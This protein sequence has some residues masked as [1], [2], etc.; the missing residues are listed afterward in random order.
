MAITALLAPSTKFKVTTA[1][2]A[3]LVGGKVYTYIAASSTLTATYADA[4]RVTTNTNPVI[5]DSRGEANIFLDPAINYKFVVQDSAGGSV[6]TQDNISGAQIGV[7]AVTDANISNTQSVLLAITNKLLTIISGTGAVY[8]S[9]LARLRDRVSLKD[10]GAVGDG[11]TN[12]TTAVQNAI[13]YALGAGIST[14]LGNQ[15]TYA[16]TSLQIYPTSGKNL[17]FLGDGSASCRFVKYGSSSDFISDYIIDI[18]GT[19]GGGGG[20]GVV[21]KI[22]LKNFGI[23]GSS[24]GVA[25]YG[26]LRIDT[27]A[28]FFM[29]GVAISGCAE[30]LKSLGALVYTIRDSQFLS[31]VIGFIA[32][33]STTN[34]GYSNLI[35]FDGTKFQGNTTYAAQLK[36]GQQIT[37]RNCDIEGNGATSGTVFI[38]D[39]T[40][41]AETGYSS[42]SWENCWWEGNN[43]AAPLIANCSNTWINIEKSNMYGAGNSLTING[44]GNQVMLKAVYGTEFL[45]M[46]DSTGAITI[47]NCLFPTYSISTPNHY[48]TNLL[49]SGGGS[50]TIR[51]ASSGT[52]LITGGSSPN[53]ADTGSGAEL[54]VVGETQS[55]LGFIGKSLL[56]INTTPKTI[57]TIKL[58]FALTFVNGNNPSGGASGWWLLANATVVNSNDS[59]GTTPVFS[60]SGSNIQMK[61]TTGTLNVNAAS[62]I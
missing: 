58:N 36:K 33:Y 26:G 39:S 56:A 16:V 45:N 29:E 6:Y 55:T 52:M 61:T 20:A 17:I 31:N 11:V 10:F 4:E 7:G 9:I 37:F 48:I 35:T 13:N 46:A 51:A 57:A 3:P 27:L 41:N 25:T 43:A 24:G 62:L 12:D 23:D 32:D 40:W 2:G 60:I 47:E 22:Q 19:A 49:G 54:Q 42:V 44:A 34:A 18:S 59:T 5:L 53:T 30:G 38:I 8:R 15:G 21:S 28:E 1:A 14:I 50:P